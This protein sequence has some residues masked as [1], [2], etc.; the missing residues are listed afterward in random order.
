MIRLVCLL[1][2]DAKLDAGDFFAGLRD[3]VGPAVAGLQARLGL[4]RYVQLHADPDAAE[5][6]RIATEL[7]GSLK[8]PFEAMADFW[9]PSHAALE[10]VLASDDGVA[11]LNQIA[12]AMEGVVDA[13]NSQCWLA[14][15]FPQVSSAPGRVAALPRSPLLKL[16]FPLMPRSGMSDAEAQSYWLTE[17]G[18]LVRSY[19]VG[20]GTTCYYQVH[21]RDYPLAS[22]IASALGFEVGRFIGHAEAWFDRSR[23]PVGADVERAKLTAAQDER[24]FIE[25]GQSFLFS[26]KEY[27]FVEREWAL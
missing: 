17:H 25:L 7:R 27:P 4:V 11:A 10:S 15:E 8:S 1:K 22:Q 20:R 3:T 9:W 23:V 24:N 18:P 13:A 16:V 2:R 6:D 12:K 14:H 26:G 5:G 21:R 19:A